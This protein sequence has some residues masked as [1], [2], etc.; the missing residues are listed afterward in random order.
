MRECRCGK[1]LEGMHGNR[2]F[3]SETC[4]NRERYVRTGQRS[5]PEQRSEWYRKRCESRE[6]RERQ[7]CQGRKRHECVIA[8]LREYKLSQGCA[9][10]GYSEHHAAL[11]FDHVR[12]KKKL[13]VC[14]A[15]SIKQAQEEIKKCRVLCSNCHRI[16]TYERAQK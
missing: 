16:C 13:N 1:S 11:E 5:T 3:C 4:A 14:L 12:G 10:C 7:R 8:F 6:Y 2:K 15:K 9:Q